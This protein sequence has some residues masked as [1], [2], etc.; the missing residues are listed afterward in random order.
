MLGYSTGTTRARGPSLPA[1]ALARGGQREGR[2]GSFAAHNLDPERPHPIAYPLWR[3]GV[4]AQLVRPPRVVTYII[5]H[6]T[7]VPLDR[8]LGVDLDGVI[9]Y[10]CLRVKNCL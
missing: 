2:R 9:I 10:P 8:P 4:V 1:T 6:P 5:R 7:N 3:V